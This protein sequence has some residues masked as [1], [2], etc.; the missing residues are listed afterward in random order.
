MA[1]AAQQLGDREFRRTLKT[2]TEPAAVAALFRTL[3]AGSGLR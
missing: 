2:S 3:P 1:S